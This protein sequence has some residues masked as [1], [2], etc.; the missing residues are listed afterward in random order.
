MKYENGKLVEEW[1]P[2]Y[3]DK[4]PD[5]PPNTRC[6]VKTKYEVHGKRTA[7]Y[8]PPHLMIYWLA[9][10]CTHPMQDANLSTVV[11]HFKPFN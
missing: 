8:N 2:F 6:F 11:T 3:F 5:L 4:L 7:I 9:D 10:D 1:E